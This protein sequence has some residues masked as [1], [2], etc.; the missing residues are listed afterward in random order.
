MRPEANAKRISPKGGV[1]HLNALNTGSGSALKVCFAKDIAIKEDFDVRASLP[2]APTVLVRQT[3]NRI[4]GEKSES[5]AT[6]IGQLP[7]AVSRSRG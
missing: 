7:S 3:S 1:T 4:L 5:C 2:D 6:R